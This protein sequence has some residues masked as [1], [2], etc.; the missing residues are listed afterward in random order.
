MIS[1]SMFATVLFSCGDS[2]KPEGD[3]SGDTSGE[4]KKPLFRYMLYGSR[5]KTLVPMMD[6]TILRRDTYCYVNL[7]KKSLLRIHPKSR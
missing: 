4:L 3:G 1:A 2:K 6:C 5:I 7:K